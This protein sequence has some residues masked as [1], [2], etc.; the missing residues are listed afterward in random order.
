MQLTNSPLMPLGQWHQEMNR[1]SSG[2]DLSSFSPYSLNLPLVGSDLASNGT[3]PLPCIPSD[4]VRQNTVVVFNT[5]I[6]RVPREVSAQTTEDPLVVETSVLRSNRICRHHTRGLCLFGNFCRF[7]HPSEE[8]TQVDV[9]RTDSLPRG[10]GWFDS[11]QGRVTWC[12]TD[13]SNAWAR[14]GP[15]M[16]QI[17]PNRAAHVR[18]LFLVGYNYDT[19]PFQLFFERT[20]RSSGGIKL[21]GVNPDIGA[22]AIANMFSFVTGE[23]VLNVDV[24]PNHAGLCVVR[25]SPDGRVPEDLEAVE[26]RCIRMFEEQK[27]WMAPASRM[28]GMLVAKDEQSREFLEGVCRASQEEVSSALFPRHLVTAQKWVPSRIRRERFLQ[29]GQ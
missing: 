5:V 4:V 11:L 9:D 23:K 18:N 19:Y 20:G 16:R 12:D 3:R 13:V 25:I 6:G 2:T 8:L 24:F 7:A 21:G 28:E 29:H 27:V 26:E 10:R 1:R 22:V 15:N 14:S 17:I